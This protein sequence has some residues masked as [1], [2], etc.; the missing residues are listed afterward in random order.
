MAVIFLY[1][2][3]AVTLLW[4]YMVFIRKSP[5]DGIPGPKPVPFVGNA[6]QLDDKH[7]HNTLFQWAKQYSPLYRLKLFNEEI[8]VVIGAKEIHEVLVC[9]GKTFAGRPH[10]FSINP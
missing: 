5:L 10:S 6:L 2:A 4:L 3:S 7:A 8:V 9:N 1:V